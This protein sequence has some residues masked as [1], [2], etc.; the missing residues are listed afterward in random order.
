MFLTLFVNAQEGEFIELECNGRLISFECSDRRIN[1]ARVEQAFNLQKGSVLFNNTSYETDGN[2]LT[3]SFGEHI[4]RLI[5]TGM[6]AGV[7]GL[8][9]RD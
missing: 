9:W 6:P 4:R 7:P 1:V 2:G 5:V 3:R 8:G